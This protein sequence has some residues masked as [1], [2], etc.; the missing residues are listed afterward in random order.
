MSIETNDKA[1]KQMK[2]NTVIRVA[3]ILAFTAV[4]RIMAALFY[5][6]RGKRNFGKPLDK[7]EKK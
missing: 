3:K 1:E 7:A 2:N 6:R 4:I 5:F